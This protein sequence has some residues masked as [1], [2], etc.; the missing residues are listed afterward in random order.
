[1][2]GTAAERETGPPVSFIAI[3]PERDETIDAFGKASYAFGRATQREAAMPKVKLDTDKLVGYMRTDSTE[4][5]IAKL[6]TSKV[7]IMK[8]VVP[9]ETPPV[10]TVPVTAR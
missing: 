8:T 9:N 5:G 7:G 6:G 1:V 2:A 10:E 3:S 4:T